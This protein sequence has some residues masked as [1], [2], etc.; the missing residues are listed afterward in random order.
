MQRIVPKG[1]PLHT[2]GLVVPSI[3]GTHDMGRSKDV[4]QPSISR[5]PT[6]MS[7]DKGLVRVSSVS[8]VS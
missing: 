8:D 7:L 6:V 3:M 5:N 2:I 4:E 1:F